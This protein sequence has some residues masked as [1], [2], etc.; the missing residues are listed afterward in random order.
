ME[1]ADAVDAAVHNRGERQ[2]N[3]NDQKRHSACGAHWSMQM[4][5]LESTKDVHRRSKASGDQGAPLR[6]TRFVFAK[7]DSKLCAQAGTQAGA[8]SSSIRLVAG[9]DVQLKVASVLAIFA[10]DPLLC[11]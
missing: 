2:N 1:N 9:Q 10:I 8:H 6:R 7:R 4:L 3:R 5:P 11:D